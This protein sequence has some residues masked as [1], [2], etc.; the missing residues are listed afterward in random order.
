QVSSAG[1]YT[2][3]ITSTI[4][5]CSGISNV[6]SLT[7]VQQPTVTVTSSNTGFCSSAPSVLT[8]ST[9]SGNTL[10]WYFNSSPVGGAT[11]SSYTASATGS[12]YCTGT[13]VT[14]GSRNSNTF[15][16]FGISPAT[17]IVTPSGT[18]Q[19]CSTA[20]PV[21]LVVSPA[22]DIPSSGN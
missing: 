4:T 7:S 9:A 19:N 22:S 12:Y 3:T 8:A 11:S 13:N 14:C 18:I 21:N 15:R 5:G 6:L 16:Y 2:C 1:N 20:Y 17:P 10:Q